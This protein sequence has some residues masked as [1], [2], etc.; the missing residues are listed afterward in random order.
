MRTPEEDRVR[1]LMDHAVAD[2][3]PRHSLDVIRSRT[4]V[5][6][7]R[8]AWAWGA[9]GAVLA[10]AAT[11]AAV[12]A[13]TGP[14]TSSAGPGPAAGHAAMG[15]VERVYFVGRTAAGPRLFP[16]PHRAAST[17]GALVQ[18]VTEAVSGSATDPDY[19]T[20]WPAGTR[21]HH[22]QLGADVLSVDLSGPTVRPAGMSRADAAMALQQLVYTA[23][24]ASGSRRPVT[25]LVDGRPAPTVL[26]EPTRRPVPAGDALTAV[27]VTSPVDGATTTSPFLVTGRAAAFEADVQWELV[28]PGGTVARRGFTTAAECCTLSPYRF[29]VQAPPGDYTLVVHDEDAS[30]GESRVPPAQDT[31]RVTVR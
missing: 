1:A 31:K 4:R 2:V 16:E 6:R 12:V 20:L 26:G 30:G 7:T 17:G 29:R 13:L 8:R 25:F 3:E 19:R 22:A 27:T 28:R 5:V 14:G 15:P 10:S 23:Q 21:V 9:G 18:A 11:V 24:D